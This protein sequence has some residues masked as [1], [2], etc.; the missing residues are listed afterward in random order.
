M[1]MAVFAVV[2]GLPTLA[3]ERLSRSLAMT[4]GPS[5]RA[6]AHPSVALPPSVRRIPLPH[7][8]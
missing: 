3:L 1:V 5:A 2:E 7:P 4:L 6:R 8:G